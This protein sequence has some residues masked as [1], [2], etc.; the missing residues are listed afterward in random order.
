MEINQ[1]GAHIDHMLRQTRM[2]NMQLS[3]MA[4]VKANILLTISSVILGFSIS[5][6]TTYSHGVIFIILAT[7]SMLTIALALYSTM[8]TWGRRKSASFTLLFFGDYANLTYE[9]YEKEMERIMNN[10]SL[11]YEV[12]VKELYN[13]GCYLSKHKFHKLRLAYIT[14]LC[15]TVLAG[16][17]A[18]LQALFA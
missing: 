1:P 7:S 5:H 13:T 14:F 16:I 2:H 4:D 6:L 12:Q 17:L 18:A 9:A 15:G 10:P 8:P 11:T 3:A